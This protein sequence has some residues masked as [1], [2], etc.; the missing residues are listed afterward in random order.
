[1]SAAQ[2]KAEWLVDLWNLLPK[3]TVDAGIF[4]DFREMLTNWQ[5]DLLMDY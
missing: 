1:V 3:D 2:F 5:R 4:Q